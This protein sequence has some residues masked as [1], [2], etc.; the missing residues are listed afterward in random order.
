MVLD[1]VDA[2]AKAASATAAPGAR[3]ASA[4]GLRIQRV[5]RHPEA[6]LSTQPKEG[7]GGPTCVGCKRGVSYPCY[8]CFECEG[9]IFLDVCI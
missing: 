3:A 9:Q 1:E 4:L 6:S 7:C 2:A 8:A 5:P